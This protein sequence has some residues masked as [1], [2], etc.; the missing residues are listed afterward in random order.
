VISLD[1][2]RIDPTTDDMSL[3]VLAMGKVTIGGLTHAYN[4]SMVLVLDGG[5]YKIKADTYRLMD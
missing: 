4:Q 2:H 1:A 5:T 3:A